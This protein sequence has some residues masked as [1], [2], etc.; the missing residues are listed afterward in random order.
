[1]EVRFWRARRSN[2]LDHGAVDCM[3]EKQHRGRVRHTTATSARDRVIDP[4]QGTRKTD[5][6]LYVVFEN[7][8]S[9]GYSG[10]A[11]E[12]RERYVAADKPEALTWAAA[13]L[14]LVPLS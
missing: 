10:H 8:Q 7:H 6:D 1:M 2:L 13:C 9:R 5:S 4:V 11:A 14:D 12:V 3:T